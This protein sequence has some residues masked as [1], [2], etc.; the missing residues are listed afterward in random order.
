[1]KR[2]LVTASE[3]KRYDANTIE[4]IGIPSLVLMERAALV[5]VEELQKAYGGKPASVLVVA[6]CGNNGGDGLAVGRLLMLQGYPVDFVLIGNRKKCSKETAAQIKILEQYGMSV[7]DGIAD[8]AYGIVID[9]L[10]GIGLSREVTGIYADA[11]ERINSLHSFVCSIDIPSG[12]DADHG[13]IW[14]CAVQADLTVTYG[15]CKRGHV[16]YPGASCC[17]KTVCREMGINERSFL[18]NPP[19]WYTLQD[20]CADRFDGAAGKELLPERSPGGNKGTFGKVLAIAGSAQACGAAILSARSA[21]RMGVGMVKVVTAAENR[22]TFLTA[23]P[24]SMLLTYDQTEAVGK[25]GAQETFGSAF[26]VSLRESLAWADALLIGPGIGT[27]AWAKGL[28]SFC[29]KNSMHP[30]VIDA[31]GLNLL[32]QDP[33]LQ[34]EIDQMSQNGRA[35]VLTPHLGE[36]SRLYGCS[37]GE[38]KE[39]LLAYPAEL[40]KRLHAV[41]VCKDAR[42]VVTAPDAKEQYLNTTGNDGMATAGSGDVLAGMITGLLAQGMEAEEAAVCGVYLHGAA[43]DLAAQKETK[44][45][46]TASD[47]IDQIG[48]AAQKGVHR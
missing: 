27:G 4:T 42:T 21:F 23:V 16:L 14:G 47:I 44:R 13:T 48:A 25:D 6:G 29:L 12:I 39:H 41:I 8:G 1:V 34:E 38:A 7:T 43:G 18:G 20:I 17:G 19:G 15:F 45:S 24:E 33:A 10:F 28:L 31:D 35:F 36:F 5:T 46:M 3:M 37:I 26:E 32:A 2:Y 30:T 22:E 40:A 9:A 11:I